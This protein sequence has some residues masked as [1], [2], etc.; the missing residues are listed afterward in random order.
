MPSIFNSVRRY[1]FALFVLFFFGAG[2]SV[3]RAA[4]TSNTPRCQLTFYTQELDRI[5]TVDAI[6]SETRRTDPWRNSPQDVAQRALKSVDSAAASAEL[7]EAS[8]ASQMSERR[9]LLT[10]E[11][12]RYEVTV[13]RPAATPGSSLDDPSARWYVARITKLECPAGITIEEALA[14]E[15]RFFRVDLGNGSH[16]ER[17][18]ETV[19]LEANPDAHASA[20]G[21]PVF[22][23]S[24]VSNVHFSHPSPSQKD[25]LGEEVQELWPLL[26]D[27][28]ERSGFTVASIIS[29]GQEHGTL[30]SATRDRYEQLAVRSPDGSWQFFAG[31]PDDGRSKM[32]DQFCPDFRRAQ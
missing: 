3:S 8:T 22:T 17:V 7:T 4:S 5:S 20:V 6:Q 30:A 13:I 24:Y 15:N 19:E 9:F 25:K 14:P 28:A 18:R 12:T 31:L 23:V 26:Q 10:S 32:I 16:L 21:C 1:S 29:L 2:A 11:S 27:D